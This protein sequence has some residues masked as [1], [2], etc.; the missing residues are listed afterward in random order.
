MLCRFRC[1][2][3]QIS[4][5]YKHILSSELPFHPPVPPSRSLQSTHVGL[6]VLYNNF[7][8]ASVSHDSVSMSVPLSQ[9][10]PLLPYCVHKCILYLHLYSFSANGFISTIFPHICIHTC[11]HIWYLFFSFLTFFTQCTGLWLHLIPYYRW[12]KSIPFYGWVIPYCIWVP[13][14]YPFMFL[15]TS[16][17]L[18]YVLAIVSRAAVNTEVHVSFKILVFTVYAQ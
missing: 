15:R 3:P 1:T 5:N 13:H 2:T 12:L 14:L 8:L 6:P 7:P 10:A 11:I 18:S 17:L 16:R 4:Y 9:F